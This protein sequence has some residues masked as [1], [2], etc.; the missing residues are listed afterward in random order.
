MCDFLQGI[1]V[2]LLQSCSEELQLTLQR[3]YQLVE[4]QLIDFRR[5][6][7]QR[8]DFKK[9][10]DMFNRVL[11]RDDIAVVVLL[12]NKAT[13]TRFVVANV[14]V[15]WD[16]QFRDVKLVQT[17]LLMDEVDKIAARFARYPPRP[18]PPPSEDGTPPPKPAPMYADGTK[19]PTIVCGDYNSTPDSGVYEFLANGSVAPDHEDFMSHLYGTYTSEGPKHRFGLKSAYASIDELPL[20]NYTS[21]FEGSIDYIWYSTANL[22]VTSLLGEVDKGYLSKVVGFPN[23]HFPSEYVSPFSF[24]SP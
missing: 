23:A 1:Q 8:A 17:A 24:L 15:F 16:A 10:E 14:H 12:E 20:T 6:A 13:G 21:S 4:K 18:P 9:T 7:M 11:Q 22:T 3:R 19:I 2:S 5:L